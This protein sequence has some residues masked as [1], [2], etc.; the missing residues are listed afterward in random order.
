MCHLAQM[1]FPLWTRDG[2]L[3]LCLP[4]WLHHSHLCLTCQPQTQPAP[5]PLQALCLLSSQSQGL[6]Y[7]SLA[8]VLNCPGRHLNPGSGAPQLACPDA[9]LHFP[10]CFTLPSPGSGVAS[11][12]VARDHPGQN[13]SHHWLASGSHSLHLKIPHKSH[14]ALTNRSREERDGRTWEVE[15]GAGSGFSVLL[16]LGFWRHFLPV[17]FGL[18]G[19]PVLLGEKALGE[20]VWQKDVL[21]WEPESLLWTLP[22][23]QAHSQRE[24]RGPGVEGSGSW[25]QCCGGAG[26]LSRRG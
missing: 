12:P 22:P 1:L 19:V 21:V 16:S 18:R 24:T 23:E 26:A 5:C 25:P 11:S 2:Q 9:G 17:G 7:C 10:S 20:V 3:G 15:L 4:A 14:K 13:Q 8:V 6:S